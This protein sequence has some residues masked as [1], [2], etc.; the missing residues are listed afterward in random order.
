MNNVRRFSITV[1][2]RV[3]GVMFRMTAKRQAER[4]GLTGSARNRSDGT[5]LLEA[6]GG[7]AALDQFIDWCRTGT[8]YSEVKDV[9]V[10]SIKPV[11]ETGFS[12][13]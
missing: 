3:Q 9:E 4:L 7:E 8:G 6:Q 2:G 5:V 10:T 1:R 12:V 13:N 11:E